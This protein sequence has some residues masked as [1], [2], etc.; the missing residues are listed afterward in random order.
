[1]I[2]SRL[3]NNNNTYHGYTVHFHVTFD[4]G[5]PKFCASDIAEADDTVIVFFYNKIIELIGGMH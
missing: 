4:V 3:W 2:G 1:M 5:R